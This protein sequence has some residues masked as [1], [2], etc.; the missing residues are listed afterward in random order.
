MILNSH[1]MD[2][3]NF[4]KFR[5]VSKKREKDKLDVILNSHEM[6]YKFFFGS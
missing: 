5:I 3:N 4:L 6:G 2:Y 1:E